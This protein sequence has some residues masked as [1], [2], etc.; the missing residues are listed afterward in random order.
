MQSDGNVL[1][2]GDFTT[3]QCVVRRYV[4]RLYGDSVAPSL[5]IARS[6]AFVIVSWPASAAGF[7]LQQNTNLN[8]GNWTTP[9]ETIADIAGDRRTLELDW[10]RTALPRAAGNRFDRRCLDRFR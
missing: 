6:N 2:G 4:A 7:V 8:A 9:P 5:N 3:G 1:I 10:R